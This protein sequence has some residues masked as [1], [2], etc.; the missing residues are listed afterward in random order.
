MGSIPLADIPGL[1]EGA[2]EGKGLG[3]DFL[4]HIEKT[5]LLVH[6]ISVE[7]VD[8]LAV[9]KTIRRE[10]KEYSSVLDKKPEIIFL[11]KNDLSSESEIKEKLSSLKKIKRKV[12]PISIYNT[13]DIENTKQ[14]FTTFVKTGK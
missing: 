9:Y 5:K 2:S 12:Y 6:C 10:L 11:T 14:L 4:R 8:I 1:I 3:T 13:Q 7:N